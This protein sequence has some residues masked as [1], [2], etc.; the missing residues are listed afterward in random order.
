MLNPNCL[1]EDLFYQFGIIL[2]NAIRTTAP[3][4][5]DLHPIVWKQINKNKLYEEDLKTSDLYR[6]QMLE[7]IRTTKCEEFEDKID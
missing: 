6:Y 7:L 1:Q 3:L 5:I 4:L 2:G